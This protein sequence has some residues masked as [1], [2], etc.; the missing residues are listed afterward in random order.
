[1]I[2]E[3]LS[4]P[5]EGARAL[6]DSVRSHL[7]A[8]QEF[9][10]R[11]RSETT[12]DAER[13]EILARIRKAHPDARIVA[14]AQYA[15]TVSMLFSRLSGVGGVAMLTARGGM[16]SG[17]RLT[18]DE[19]LARFA[20]RASCAAPPPRAQRIGLLL[21]TDLLSEG[22]NLQDAEVVVHVD[23]PWTAARMEQRVGRVARLGSVHPRVYVYLIRPPATATAVLGSE[24]LVQ[25]KWSTAKRMVGSSANAPFECEIGTGKKRSAR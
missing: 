25:R 2:P 5:V 12:L 20:P 15:E 1:M 10:G 6:L 22:V 8:L 13:A 7:D 11:R 19:T 23:V 21:T 24:L 17:G 4:S 14:F 9:H 18:R 16:V 3:L